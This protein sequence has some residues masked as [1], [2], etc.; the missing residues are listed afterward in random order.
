MLICDWL[1][2]AQRGELAKA[3]VRK[4]PFSLAST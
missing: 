3:V 2:L 1:K 4:A